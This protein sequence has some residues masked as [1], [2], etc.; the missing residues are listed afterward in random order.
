MLGSILERPGSHPD[1]TLKTSVADPDPQ[2]PY[3]VGPPGSGSISTM[4]GSGFFNH[5]ANVVRKTLIPTVLRLLYDFF[6][7][8]K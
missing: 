1:P 4:Y 7:I 6:I 2:D 8:E 3:V 5:Q